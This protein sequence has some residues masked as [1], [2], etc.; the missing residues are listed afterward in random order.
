MQ[1]FY[2]YAERGLARK[3]VSIWLDEGRVQIAYREALVARY[4]STYDR[5]RKRLR[6][7]QQPVLYQTAYVRITAVRVVG[8]G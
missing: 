5:R 3:R 2:I 7:V 1:R 6:S 4:S 8:T